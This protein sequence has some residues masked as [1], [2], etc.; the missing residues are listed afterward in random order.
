MTALCI[1]V[2]E[3]RNLASMSL[4]V[5]HPC[6]VTICAL[7]TSAKAE[8]LY[9]CRTTTKKKKKKKK[10]HL[11]LHLSCLV[12]SLEYPI[13][14]LNIVSANIF[15]PLGK[16]IGMVRLRISFILSSQSWEIGRPPTGS[17]QSYSS[18]PF[19]HLEERSSTSVMLLPNSRFAYIHTYIH[20]YTHIHT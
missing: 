17:Y 3:Q 10:T 18:D 14:N 7:Q 13:M 4:S 16:M 6:K 2:L 8:I 20:I 11:C 19:M 1:C 15:F 9:G 12:P 5:Y